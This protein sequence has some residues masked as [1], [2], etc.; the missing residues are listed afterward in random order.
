MFTRPEWHGVAVPSRNP[1]GRTMLGIAAM[2][3]EHLSRKW[4]VLT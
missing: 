4:N 2:E 1:L 3:K